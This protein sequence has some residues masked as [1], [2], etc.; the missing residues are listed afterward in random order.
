MFL[1]LEMEDPILELNKSKICK[2]HTLN[3]VNSIL[4]ILDH[5]I[6]NNKLKIKNG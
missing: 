4:L 3:Y 5:W 2:L 6:E 1:K